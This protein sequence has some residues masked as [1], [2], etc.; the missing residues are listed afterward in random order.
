MIKLERTDPSTG[1][2]IPVPDPLNSLDTIAYRNE[3]IGQGR[4]KTDKIY[5]KPYK[6][7]P[8]RTA[9]MLFSSKKC[10]F[11]EQRL[12]IATGNTHQEDD[13]SREHFRPKSKYWWLA[14]SWDNLL[15]VCRACNG[16]KD[17]DFDITGTFRSYLATDLVNIHNLAATYNAV[18]QPNYIHPEWDDPETVLTFSA[19]GSINSTDSR[20]KNTIKAYDL[21]RTELQRL[22]KQIYDNFKT[23]HDLIL[24]SGKTDAEKKADIVTKFR[25][26]TIEA[27]KTGNPFLGF[28]RHIMR[29]DIRGMVV[30]QL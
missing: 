23:E 21:N 7:S 12:N 3:L 19:N 15:P 11:C 30:S 28:R 5:T 14:Y 17:H 18:E 13:F 1:N 25:A 24:L 2:P 6:N 9:L 16:V 27:Y 10:S 20:A 8:V 26:F 4:W 29:N 22:R